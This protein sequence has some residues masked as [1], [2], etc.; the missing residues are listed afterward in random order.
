MIRAVFVL[1]VGLIG[2]GIIHIGAV[3]GLARFVEPDHLARFAAFGPDHRFN[4][5]PRVTPQAQPLPLLDPAFAHALCRFSIAAEP[6]RLR[7]A[8]PDKLWTLALYDR[9]GVNVYH[10]NDR[11]G[12]GKAV[13]LLVMTARQIAHLREK[14]PEDLDALTVVEWSGE[15]QGA[16]LLRAYAPTPAARLQFTQSLAEARCVPLSAI[17]TT[18]PPPAAPP[19]T[20]QPANPPVNP[21]AAPRPTPR[22]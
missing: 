8:P 13:E 17:E 1:L 10:L 21:P 19:T 22:R 6:M 14:P 15:P 5:L 2:A 3:L 4:V 9:H 12:D 18:E 7:V 20:P 11:V 16:A